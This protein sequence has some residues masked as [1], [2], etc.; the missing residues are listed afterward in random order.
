[1]ARR[2][3]PSAHTS[4]VAMLMSSHLRRGSARTTLVA[5]AAELKALFRRPARFRAASARRALRPGTRPAHRH[6]GGPRTRPLDTIR[7]AIEQIDHAGYRLPKG[8]V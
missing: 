5:G 2:S 7:I 4:T 1:M 8:S 3:S 6:T